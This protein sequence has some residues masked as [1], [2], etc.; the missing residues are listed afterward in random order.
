VE[1]ELT[2]LASTAAS[3]VVKSLA[4]TAWD[5][6]KDGIGALWRRVHPER[7]ETI[8]AE[9]G[10]AR[11]EIIEA[12][13]AEDE[14]AEQ[15]IVAEWAVRLRRLLAT[16]PDVAVDLRRLL[17]QVLAPALAEAGGQGTS[18]ITMQATAVD[19]G[20]V[21]QAGRDQHIIER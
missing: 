13:K 15:D 10:E 4:T 20:R 21:N 14:R 8:Q 11:S 3:V 2:E 18:S 6:A 19:G 16:N 17:D 9:L 12:R 1:S 7:A 5:K